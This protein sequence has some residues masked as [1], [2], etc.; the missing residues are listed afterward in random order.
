MNGAQLSKGDG[1][2][3]PRANLPVNIQRQRKQDDDDQHVEKQKGKPADQF[4]QKV[5]T[6]ARQPSFNGLQGGAH[7]SF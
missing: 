3:V 2:E 7:V 6:V 1:P 5:I 4:D